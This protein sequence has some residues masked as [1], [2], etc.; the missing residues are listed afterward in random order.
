[1]LDCFIAFAREEIEAFLQ[2][3]NLLKQEF[4]ELFKLCQERVLRDGGLLLLAVIP[5]L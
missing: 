4:L 3:I 1:M 5:I 2:F